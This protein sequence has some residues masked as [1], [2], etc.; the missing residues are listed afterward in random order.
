MVHASWH[1]DVRYFRTTGCTTSSE[2]TQEHSSAVV[3][4]AVARREG[5]SAAGTGQCSV[6]AAS[7]DVR[8]LQEQSLPMFAANFAGF[9]PNHECGNSFVSLPCDRRKPGLSSLR[10]VSAQNA[11]A[12][13]LVVPNDVL[14]GNV[15][16]FPRSSMITVYFVHGCGKQPVPALSFVVQAFPRPVQRC[17]RNCAN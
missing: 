8:S 13:I 14:A 5:V 12:K 17:V 11:F 6:H 15:R 16:Y 2:T 1:S 7:A 4:G 9:G 10:I 3:H